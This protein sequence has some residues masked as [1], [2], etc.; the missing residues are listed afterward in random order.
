VSHSSLR[1]GLF[2]VFVAW[3]KLAVGKEYLSKLGKTLHLKKSY[4]ETYFYSPYQ[5]KIM[6]IVSKSEQE[7]NVCSISFRYKLPY[8]WPPLFNQPALLQKG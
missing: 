5:R 2:C 3:V 8:V 4:K 7:I 6:F 1:I